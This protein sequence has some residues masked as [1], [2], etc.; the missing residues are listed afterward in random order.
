MGAERGRGDEHG[1]HHAFDALRTGIPSVNYFALVL[2]T[3][4]SLFMYFF[5]RPLGLCV[6]FVRV[7][8]LYSFFLRMKR[9]GVFSF[10]GHKRKILR[11]QFIYRVFN[12]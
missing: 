9:S 5:G 4:F 12:D 6:L 8:R 1:R 3:F 10:V 11:R 7:K 2:I